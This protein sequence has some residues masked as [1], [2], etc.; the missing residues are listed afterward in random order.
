MKKEF[1]MLVQCEPESDN[2]RLS[3]MLTRIFLEGEI[4][5]DLKVSQ[6]NIIDPEKRNKHIRSIIQLLE[7]SI[8][9]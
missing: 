8:E 3:I 5:E 7:N 2:W 1:D 9:E 4:P 6:N